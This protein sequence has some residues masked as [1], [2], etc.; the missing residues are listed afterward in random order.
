[1]MVYSHTQFGSSSLIGMGMGAIALVAS[2]YF[3]RTVGPT[4]NWPRT[5][6]VGA[7]VIATTLLVGT[8]LAFSRM[9]IAVE[10][11][12]LSWGFMMGLWGRRVPLADI[13]SVTAVQATADDGWGIHNTPGGTLYNVAG[14]SAVQ[15]RLKDGSVF[16]LGTDQPNQLIHAI[17]GASPAASQ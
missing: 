11:G 15:V 1:M 16:R 14:S 10:D 6:V 2:G 5:R 4:R 7:F 8:G 17:G 3:L 12:T 13:T 9:T